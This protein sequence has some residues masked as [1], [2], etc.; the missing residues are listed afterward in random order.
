MNLIIERKFRLFSLGYMEYQVIK[1]DSNLL[2]E[3]D[4][5]IIRYIG[6]I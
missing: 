2:P 6:E 5:Q 3:I 1:N 4:D